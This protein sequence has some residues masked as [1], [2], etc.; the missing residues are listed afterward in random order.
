MRSDCLN[1]PE[2]GRFVDQ[3]WIDL[4]PGL[5]PGIDVLR[6]T[7]FNIAYWNLATRRLDDDGDGGYRVDGE[8][9]RFFH[10]SG[11]DPRHPTELSKHQDRIDV[12]ANPP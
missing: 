8:P 11:F 2:Q 12:A 7:A 9:L 4:A 10:F 6:D 3:R 5:W 1:E